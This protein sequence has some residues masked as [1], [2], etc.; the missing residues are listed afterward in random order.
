MGSV[1]S[2]PTMPEEE[3]PS[4]MSMDELV[5]KYVDMT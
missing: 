5:V 3:E 1:T 4:K 2:L